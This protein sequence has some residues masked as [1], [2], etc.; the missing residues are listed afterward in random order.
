MG[1]DNNETTQ[2][3]D[4]RQDEQQGTQPG[5]GTQ[6]EAVRH[7]SEMLH[8]SPDMINTMLDGL[9]YD[10][11]K[12]A[13]VLQT[14]APSYIAIKGRFEPRKRGE[15]RGAFCILAQ[16][17][18]GE[19]LNSVF[20][21]GYAE[22][23]AGFTIK[24]N[25]EAVRTAINGITTMPDRILY[26]SIQQILQHQMAPTTVN[27]LFQDEE[28]FDRFRE[29][30][31]QS[32]SDAFR[33][34][35]ILDLHLERFNKTRLDMSGLMK[36]EE[37]EEEP[38]AEEEKQHSDALGNIRVVCA[39]VLDPVQGKAV[40]EINVGD[41]VEVTFDNS[42]GLGKMIGRLFSRTGRRPTFPV[43]SA[44]WTATGHM[45][46][47]LAVTE[48]VIGVMNLSPNLRVSTVTAGEVKTK[49]QKGPP[50]QLIGLGVI[51][52]VS[53]VLIFVIYRF[54]F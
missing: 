19:W 45:Y 43:Q 20:W 4:N 22:F 38:Q 9:K 1:P 33:M 37:A 40:S 26:K 35:V 27:M 32:L 29:E 42:S 3:Q 5:A 51:L 21:V 8:T 6:A 12:A 47:E 36:Q 34:E 39:P 10:P 54:L 25:W 7:L 18:S 41:V 24:A 16:G 11:E 31:K 2:S 17:H 50:P 48:G 28:A 14:L 46:V 53:A 15:A 44:E 13:T 30:L 23:P 52:A 49:Q